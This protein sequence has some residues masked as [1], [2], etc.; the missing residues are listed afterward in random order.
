MARVEPTAWTS[1]GGKA[2]RKQLATKAARRL[3]SATGG[4]RKPHRFRSGSVALREI[5]KYQKCM[6]LLIR[7]LP[8]RRL[9]RERAYNLKTDLR[10]LSNAVEEGRQSIGTTTQFEELHQLTVVFHAKQEGFHRE[11]LEELRQLPLCVN[12][13]QHRLYHPPP[14]SSI[15]PEHSPPS[16]SNPKPYLTICDKSGGLKPQN[17]LKSPIVL[18]QTNIHQQCSKQID[19]N[20]VSLE[21]H[22]LFNERL[23]KPVLVHVGNTAEKPSDDCDSLT[24]APSVETCFLLPDQVIND[25]FMKDDEVCFTTPLVST[26]IELESKE[27]LNVKS[28]VV[29][30]LWGNASGKFKSDIPGSSYNNLFVNLFVSIS[31]PYTSHNWRARVD[32]FLAAVIQCSVDPY[33]FIDNILLGDIGGRVSLHFGSMT[34]RQTRNV[35]KK[36]DVIW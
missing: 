33:V 10:F 23:H 32:W 2:P 1:T 34:E 26:R 3:A 29:E 24:R 31:L 36:F 22:G 13:P 18:H 21:L 17:T 9:V 20:L 30:P 7:K 6:K 16:L 28:E 15:A 12:P 8:F 27:P 4:V 25:G 19:E 11:F 5:K 35:E 14:P